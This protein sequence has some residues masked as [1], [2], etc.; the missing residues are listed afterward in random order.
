MCNAFRR[1]FLLLQAILLADLRA[2]FKIHV[3]ANQCVCVRVCVCAGVGT[4]MI[5][6][7]SAGAPR[8][9]VHS[10]AETFS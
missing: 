5:T 8:N 3:K 2:A 10:E 9:R 7:S 1:K 4:G 6:V